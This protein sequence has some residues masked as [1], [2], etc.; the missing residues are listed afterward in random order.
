MITAR[1]RDGPTHAAFGAEMLGGVDL[2]ADDERTAEVAAIER[3]SLL[4]RQWETIDPPEPVSNTTFAASPKACT[5]QSAAPGPH[6]RR[7]WHIEDDLTIRAWGH[8]VAGTS[9]STT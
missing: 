4:A 3:A 8:M 5:S 7:L 1:V 9:S 6:N 2:R